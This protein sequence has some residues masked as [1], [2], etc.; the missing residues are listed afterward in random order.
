MWKISPNKKL[1]FIYFASKCL[2]FGLLKQKCLF[3]RYW[4]GQKTK[5]KSFHFSLEKNHSK[6]GKIDPRY[7]LQGKKKLPSK[8]V[9]IP[10]FQKPKKIFPDLLLIFFFIVFI[11]FF[12]G[13]FTHKSR[14]NS[15]VFKLKI[16]ERRFLFSILSS[17]KFVKCRN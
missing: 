5:K 9:S 13:I 16:S 1:S 7:Y 6:K 10:L 17:E 12:L 4:A 11:F 8:N 3:F 15:I 2:D 14:L